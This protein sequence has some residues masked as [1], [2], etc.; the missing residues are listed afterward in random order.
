MAS[1]R[2]S[3]HRRFCF[4][5]NNPTGEERARLADI[6]NRTDYLVFGREI[7]P[8]TGTPHLQGYVV[9]K[10]GIT[11][12]DFKRLTTARLHVEVARGSHQQNREYCIKDGDF[13]EYGVLPESRQGERTDINSVITWATA[14]GTDNG[15]PPSSPEIARAFPREY[16]KLNRL[17]RTLSHIVP[18]Q[19]LQFG[20]PRPWQ[21]ELELALLGPANDRTVRFV[22]DEDGDKGKS[23]F[24]RYFYTKYPDVT[25]ML[26][27]GK[28]DDVAFAIDETKSVFLINVPRGS[29]E[30]LQ[31]SVLEM[32]KD[33]VIFS[34]KYG[35]KTKVMAKNSHVVVFSNEYPDL[36]KMSEDRFNVQVLD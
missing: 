24:T 11:I 15:R 9:F 2:N 3:R 1:R 16:C 7:A 12:L 5:L 36:T 35:S 34:P 20:D 23:W 31:Y 27:I 25:Q 6:S 8:T 18:T 4:T 30:F 28:R 14:F 33:R 21:H 19:A 32:I 13:N 17:V 22:I 10:N 29:M 26:G